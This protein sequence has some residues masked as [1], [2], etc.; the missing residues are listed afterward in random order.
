MAFTASTNGLLPPNDY[1][2]NLLEEGALELVKQARGEADFVL[3]MVHYGTEYVRRPTP[4]QVKWMEALARA[5]ADVILGCHPH[6]LQPL[7]VM[8]VE[9]RRVLAAYSLGNFISAQND[10]YTDTG[11]MLS[12]SFK[13]E[14]QQVKVIRYW[15]E[16]RVEPTWVCRGEGPTFRVISLLDLPVWLEDSDKTEVQQVLRQTRALMPEVN[17]KEGGGV[18]VEALVQPLG[19]I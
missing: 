11:M 7:A 14:S 18:T 9:G 10:Q 5:G 13:K 8:E 2:V 15:D 16:V 1:C 3:V 12:L 19:E 17:L 6:V 4:E